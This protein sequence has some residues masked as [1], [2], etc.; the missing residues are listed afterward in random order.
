MAP[1]LD[2]QMFERGVSS[3]S[4]R[5]G[6]RDKRWRVIE[7]RWPHAFIAVHAAERNGAPN[8]YVFRFDCSNYPQNA[9]TAQ[10]WMPSLGGPLPAN[11]W[12]TG[13]SRVPAAFNPAWKNGIC[14]YLPCDRLAMEGHDPWRQKYPSYLWAPDKGIIRYLEIVYELLNSRDYTGIRSA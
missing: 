8:E 5:L 13:A 7:I 3:A 14:L 6:V 2:Q 9:V 1:S 4:F 10:P 12:P 11:Q